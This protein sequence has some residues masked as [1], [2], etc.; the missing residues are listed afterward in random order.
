MAAMRCVPDQNYVRIGLA[1]RGFCPMWTTMLKL[2]T[3]W[4]PP[5]GTALFRNVSYIVC[6]AGR[7]AALVGVVARRGA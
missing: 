6:M 4:L 5:L 1:M 2:P 7:G 3:L